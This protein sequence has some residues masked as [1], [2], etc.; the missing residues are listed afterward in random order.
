MRLPG[1]G[2]AQAAFLPGTASGCIDAPGG[3]LRLVLCLPDEPPPPAGYALIV[4]PDAGFTFGTLRD[5]VRLQTGA[6]ADTGLPAT[7]VAGLGY[8]TPDWVDMHRRTTDLTGPASSGPG[9]AATLRF[10]EHDLLP[11]LAD[12][13]RL[14]PERRMLL[15]HSFGGYFAL[16][17]LADRPGLFSHVVASSPSIWVDPEAVF[18]GLDALRPPRP[19]CLMLSAGDEE[20]AAIARARPGAPPDAERLARLQERHMVARARDAAARLAAVPGL[21]VRFRLF[22]GEGH[23]SVIPAM[24]SRAVGLLAETPAGPGTGSVPPDSR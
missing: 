16:R 17:A 18:A 14:D 6:R 19:V 22:E 21:D 11:A 8:P 10:L 2:G 20:D 13:Y 4:A 1:S 3:A 9:R 23:G 15:G 7:I 24:L 5:V 12:A